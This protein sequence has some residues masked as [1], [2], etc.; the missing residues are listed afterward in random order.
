MK[1]KT[2]LNLLL[3]ITLFLGTQT[4]MA[5]N[6]F[7]K[8]PELNGKIYVSSKNLD[9]TDWQAVMS[10]HFDYRGSRKEVIR[11][12]QTFVRPL[13]NNEYSLAVK[14]GSLTEIFPASWRLLTC[15]YKI[16]LIGKNTDLGKSAFG[17][18]YLMGQEHGEMD[19]EELKEMQNTEH[20][21][22]LLTDKVRDL[23]I[24]IAQ[25][26]GIILE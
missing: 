4:A 24:S 23:T 17:E 16:I 26:G 22:K 19:P 25:N 5:E 21:A 11:Y 8:T 20:V 10:C 12:P 7:I 18:I 1:T 9:L 2:S 3:T 14:K 6:V 13:E 15:A